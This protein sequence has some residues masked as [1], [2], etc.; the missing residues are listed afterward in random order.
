[1]TLQRLTRWFLPG[2]RAETE[3][4]FICYSRG[5]AMLQTLQVVA[6]S[7][8]IGLVNSRFQIR[9]VSKFSS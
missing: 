5:N 6:N 7:S 4:V 1:M 8:G 3:T 9:D 2:I